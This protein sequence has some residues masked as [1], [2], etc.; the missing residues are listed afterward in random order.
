MSSSPG[1]PNR[2]PKPRVIPRR[3]ARAALIVLAIVALLYLLELID[4]LFFQTGFSTPTRQVTGLDANGIQPRELDGLDGI[5][6]APFLHLGF[7]HLMANTVPL[8]VLGWLCMAGGVRQ[9]VAVTLVVLLV[10]GLGTWLA[11]G[12]GSTHLGASGIAFGW[13]LFLLVRGF[14]NRSAGQILVAVVLFVY[15]GGM[16]WGVLPGGQPNV[17]WQAH[18]FG[19]LGGVLAA[20]LVRRGDRAHRARPERPDDLPGRLGT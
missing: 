1:G 17:S 9:F 18:L 4:Q 19:A 12:D 16:L 8:L 15:W 2:A 5:L 11:G 14:F 10:G 3:P 7:G 6:W 13:L 20:W